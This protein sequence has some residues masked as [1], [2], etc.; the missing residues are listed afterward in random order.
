MKNILMFSFA[1]VMMLGSLSCNAQTNKK[2]VTKNTVSA[3]VEVYYF[4]FTQ[5]CTTCHAVEDNAKLAVESL[6][7]DKVKKDEYTFKGLNLDDASSK[8]IAK[9]L[10][11]GGQTLLVVCGGKKVDITDK[12]FMNAH[13]PDKMKEEIKK[14]V[15]QVTKG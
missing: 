6:Y 4:H 3:K 5:R 11:V 9:K 1:L 8:E 15:D 13:N 14:A 7:A 12:G 2:I 10:G